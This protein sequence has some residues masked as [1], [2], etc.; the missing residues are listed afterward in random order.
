MKVGFDWNIFLF[1]VGSVRKFKNRKFLARYTK[2]Y[3]SREY[4][5]YVLAGSSAQ[6]NCRIMTNPSSHNITMTRRARLSK[7]DVKRSQEMES[8][9]FPNRRNT[10]HNGLCVTWKFI[11]P[12]NREKLKHISLSHH[13]HSERKEDGVQPHQWMNLWT[14]NKRTYRIEIKRYSHHLWSQERRYFY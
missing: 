11:F 2:N 6:S 14:S 3:F 7:S 12:W 10:L 5:F 13:C 1:V 4:G 8:N 9:P